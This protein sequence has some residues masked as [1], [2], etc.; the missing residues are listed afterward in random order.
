VDPRRR[1]HGELETIR[2]VP[3]ADPDRSPGEVAGLV[4]GEGLGDLDVLQQARREKSPGWS[5]E[6][7]LATWMFSSRPAGKMS[8]GTTRRFGSGLGILVSLSWVLL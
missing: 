7:V 8:M 1:G 6:K 2:E 3:G 4:G 5:G